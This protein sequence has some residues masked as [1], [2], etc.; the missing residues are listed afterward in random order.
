MKK[1]L[2]LFCILAL[3]ASALDSTW[4]TP[5]RPSEV[6]TAQVALSTT[7]AQVIAGNRARR[8]VCIRNQDAS[9]SVYVGP[10]G[11]TTA[12]GI[13]L[14]AGDPMTLYTTGPIFA[15]AASG[16]PTVGYLAEND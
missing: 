16:T 2:A 12:T 5:G 9:I 4:S 10:T 14:K 11:V 13:L 7:A 3:G 15:V 8:S 6:V 1:L